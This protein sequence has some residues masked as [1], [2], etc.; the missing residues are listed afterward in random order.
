M[1]LGRRGR[2]VSLVLLGPRRDRIGIA[3]GA[4]VVAGRI[5]TRRDGVRRGDSGCPVVRGGGVGHPVLRLGG[6]RQG[7]IA[8]RGPLFGQADDGQIVQPQVA[9]RGERDVQLTSSTIDHEQIW[10]LP[11]DALSRALGLRFVLGACLGLRLTRRSATAE[12][13]GQHFVH[14]TVIV[15]CR[16]RAHVEGAVAFLVGQSVGER[17]DG[18]HGVVATEM[19]DVAAFDAPRQGGESKS[20]LYLGESLLDVVFGP[21]QLVERVLGVGV[22]EAHEVRASA[23]LRPDDLAALAA[24]LGQPFGRALGAVRQRGHDDLV[25]DGDGNVSRRVVLRDERGDDLVVRQLHAAH[26]KLRGVGDLAGTDEEHRDLDQIAFSVEPH[27][28][29]IDVLDRH[30]AL[31]LAY[32]FHRAELVAVRGSQLE[33]ELT[34]RLFHPFLQLG[35]EL[36]VPAIQEEPHGPHLVLVP[37]SVHVI[38]ARGEA[39]ADLILQAGTFA[40]RELLVRARAELKVLVDEVQRAACRRGGVIGPEVARAVGRGASHDLHPRPSRARVDAQADV[41]LVVAKLDVES[42]LMLLDQ[43]VF[44]DG[45]LLLGTGDDRLEIAHGALQKRHE[46]AFIARGSLKV[47]PHARAQA[48]R[49]ADVDDDALA[50]LE[51]VAAGLSGQRVE[52]LED[53]V[54]KHGRQ[55]TLRS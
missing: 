23:P 41:A 51:Q 42:R 26:G 4:R 9:C 12:A 38:D 8:R 5:G 40:A 28:V 33:R 25:G 32:G 45:R 6:A 49:L 30:D 34:R 43:R 54:G 15:G 44:E 1:L 14:G 18:A 7:R 48:L 22:G 24:P 11:I 47:A 39:A 29:L 3:T 46:V 21:T 27:H 19:R 53:G 50:I 36:V 55:K 13:P 35:A 16:G 52:F 10:Q 2:S 37:S 17:D 20:L 31:L